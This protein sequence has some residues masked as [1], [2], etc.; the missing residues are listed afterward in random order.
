MTRTV[1]LLVVLLGSV[2]C[3][4]SPP[5]P[6]VPDQCAALVNRLRAISAGTEVVSLPPRSEDDPFTDQDRMLLQATEDFAA[7]LGV[8]QL[9]AVAS[10]AEAQE[11]DPYQ[12]LFARGMVDRDR[13]DL[14]GRIVVAFV[15]RRPDSASYAVPKWWETSFGS[16]DDFQ[17]LSARLSASFLDEFARGDDHHRLAVARLLGLGAAESKLSP[18]EFRAHLGAVRGAPRGK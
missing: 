1:V 15:V 7:A 11:A 17:E 8:D 4:S 9:E 2:R 18:E 13:V 6:T 14:A 3:S 16:R 5:K 12:L 10:F